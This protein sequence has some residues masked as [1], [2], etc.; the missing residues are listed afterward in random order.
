VPFV[1]GAGH[2][3][4]LAE[5]EVIVLEVR[6]HPAVLLRPFFETLAVV[7]I[8]SLLGSA[9]S[10]GRGDDAIDTLLGWIVLAFLVRFLWKGLEWTADHIVL[11]DQ[12]MFEVSGVLTRRVGSLPLVKLT[13]LTYTRT[14]PGRL[15]RYGHL[16]VET[17]GQQQA[18]TLIRFLPHPDRFYQT[19]N[20]LVMARYPKP[21]PVVE[22]Q[23]RSDDE[24][25]GPLPRVIV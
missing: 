11:S 2:M 1:W 24:D 13:D 18:L 23:R 3:R 4:Y 14:L 10:P 19:L 5:D 6:R 17:P 9:A 20:G 25:T 22:E 16:K 15:L 7:G 21:Q 12:R 8:A